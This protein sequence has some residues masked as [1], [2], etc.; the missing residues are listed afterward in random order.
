MGPYW[1]ATTNYLHDEAQNPPQV[2]SLRLPTYDRA[3]GQVVPS[4]SNIN[5][6]LQ[7]Y[8][9]EKRVL[10]LF[11]KFSGV[12]TCGMQATYRLENNEFTLTE[13]REKQ[14]CE[15]TNPPG[16]FPQVYP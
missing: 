13:F 8:E 14:E 5:R 12:G 15:G 4:Q 7:K 6:G 2:Q 3:T 11:H 10:T 1:E 9:A 16:D